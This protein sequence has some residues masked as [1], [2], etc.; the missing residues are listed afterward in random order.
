MF[1]PEKTIAVTNRIC[2][3]DL[4]LM[5]DKSYPQTEYLLQGKGRSNTK[6]VFK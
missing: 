4:H 6:F 3:D 1:I 2:E 5:Y